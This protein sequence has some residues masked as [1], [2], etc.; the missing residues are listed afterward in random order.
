[1]TSFK[2]FLRHCGLTLSA[3]LFATSPASAK[4]A[5]TDPSTDLDPALWV[6]SDDDTT[7][8]LFGTIHILR[9]GLTWFDD[10]IRTA[11][12]A[13]DEL[14][15]EIVEP[16]TAQMAQI[17]AGMA[18]D[19]SGT[20]LRDKLSPQER[21]EYESAMASIN[22][23]AGAFDQFEPWFAGVTLTSLPLLSKGYD[24]NSGAEKQLTAA[25]TKEGKPIGELETPQFQ[26][27]LFDTLSEKSQIAFLDSVVE[28][29][30]QLEQEIDALV[31]AWGKGDTER[32]G[33]LMNESMEGTN[34]LRTLL[35]T[36]RNQSWAKWIKT[37]LE[38]PGKVFI[39]VGAGHL[40]GP[41]SVQDQLKSLGIETRRIE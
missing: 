13:S 18:V 30:P 9:P 5:V 4:D 8:Y 2:S 36:N 28:S 14:V 25:A 12:D 17:I 7:I 41:D 3:L 11:F 1:M 24:L 21:A 32:L 29:V 34:E 40:A 19:T 26:L 37:R 15:L 39:A 33:A 16:D 27:G 38:K 22:L 6:V 23:P 20:S 35:L 31:D 10:G